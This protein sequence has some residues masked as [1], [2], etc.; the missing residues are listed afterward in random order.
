MNEFKAPSSKEQFDDCVVHSIEMHFESNSSLFYL[1]QIE[2]ENFEE[3]VPKS[4]LPITPK[5]PFVKRPL[6]LSIFAF[7]NPPTNQSPEEPRIHETPSDQCFEELFEDEPMCLD[8]S[9]RDVLVSH[10]PP[11]GIIDYTFEVIF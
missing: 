2:R 3:F 9:T 8:E 11:M 5:A 1:N 6:D 4:S 10:T 7:E